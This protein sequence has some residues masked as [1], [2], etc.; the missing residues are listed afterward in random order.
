MPM[1]VL[2]DISRRTRSP[3][4]V[5]V[6]DDDAAFLRS[7]ARLL[8]ATGYE[9]ATYASPAEALQ[10][11]MPRLPRCIILDVHMPGMTGFEL[12]ERLAAKGLRVPVLFVTALDVQQTRDRCKHS[13]C[14][15]LLLKPFDQQ[16]LLAAVTAAGDGTPATDTG[17]VAR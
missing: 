9:V 4:L 11:D 5:V 7:V 13:Q 10:A 16:E 3:R 17:T 15:G 2:E 14:L 1:A 6:V 8:Q 12:R